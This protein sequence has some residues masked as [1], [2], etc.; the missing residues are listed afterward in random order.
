MHA[1][2]VAKQINFAYYKNHLTLLVF[3]PIMKASHNP[4]HCATLLRT[5]LGISHQMRRYVQW[6]RANSNTCRYLKIGIWGRIFSLFGH[7]ICNSV[8]GAISLFKIN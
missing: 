5:L 8:N 6:S 1:Y 2:M 4:K 7:L 3:F